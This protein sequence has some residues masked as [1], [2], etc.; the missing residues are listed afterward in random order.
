VSFLLEFIGNLLVILL[1]KLKKIAINIIFAMLFLKLYFYGLS[2]K[3]FYDA[4]L[5]KRKIY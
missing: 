5:G 4:F 3:T 2:Y 1:K